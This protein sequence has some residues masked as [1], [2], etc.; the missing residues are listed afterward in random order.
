MHTNIKLLLP[1]QNNFHLVTKPFCLKWSITEQSKIRSVMWCISPSLNMVILNI[2]SISKTFHLPEPVSHLLSIT[3][4]CAA[5]CIKTTDS[6][7]TTDYTGSTLLYHIT[8]MNIFTVTN[9]EQN[10]FLDY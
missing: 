7:S 5:M 8:K 9:K 4:Y 10:T 1:H 3:T 6:V 2:L